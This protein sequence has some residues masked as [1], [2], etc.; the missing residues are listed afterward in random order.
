MNTVPTMLQV[1]APYFCAGAKVRGQK[2]VSA[3]PIIKYMIGWTVNKAQQYA[4]SKGWQ[5]RII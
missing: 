2:I 5:A 4:T 1:T 3:A